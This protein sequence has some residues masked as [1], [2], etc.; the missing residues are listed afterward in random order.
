MLASMYALTVSHDEKY[1]IDIV[2]LMEQNSGRN[3]GTQ[4][5]VNKYLKANN[6]NN[7]QESAKKKKQMIIP[8]WNV[9]TLLDRVATDRPERR[10]TLVA[11]ELDKYNIDITVLSETRFHVEMI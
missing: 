6:I 10:T 9:R 3:P 11:I 2:G 4:T 5:E 8:Q 1:V 7:S